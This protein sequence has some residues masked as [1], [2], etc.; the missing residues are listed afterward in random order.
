MT[1]RNASDIDVCLPL[2]WPIFSLPCDCAL[3]KEALIPTFQRLRASL[4]MTTRVVIIGSGVLGLEVQR[5]IIF[6]V[7]PLSLDGLCVQDNLRCGPC[8]DYRWWKRSSG[9]ERALRS[10]G[11]ETWTRS[12]GFFLSCDKILLKWTM[13]LKSLS[14]RCTKA[15][16]EFKSRKASFLFEVRGVSSE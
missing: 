11:L 1:I 14:L 12:P 8:D 13:A 2:I 4:T 7:N 5:S 10:A 3:Q 15:Y 6:P 9:L 16:G